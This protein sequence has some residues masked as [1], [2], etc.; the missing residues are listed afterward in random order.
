MSGLTAIRSSGIRIDVSWKVPSLIEAM[1]FVV[2]EVSFRAAMG[3]GAGGRRKRQEGECTESPC[4]VP[5]EEGGV[6]ITG[7]DADVNYVVSVQPVNGEGERI[8]PK[9]ITGKPSSP[10]REKEDS[11]IILFPTLVCPTSC[12]ITETASFP[13]LPVVVGVVVGVFALS[14]IVVSCIIILVCW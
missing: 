7:L 3:G 1:G 8:D 13:L 4:S 9:A 14:I 5:V 6:V 10:M 11:H 2:Y 12:N